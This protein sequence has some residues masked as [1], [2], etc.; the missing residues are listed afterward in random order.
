MSSKKDVR[1]LL[2]VC[3]VSERQVL[4]VF[5]YHPRK[6]DWLIPRVSQTRAEAAEGERVF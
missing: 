6:R 2:S 4:V 3:L 5:I 1:L